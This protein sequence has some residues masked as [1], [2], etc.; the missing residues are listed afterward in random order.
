MEESDAEARRWLHNSTRSVGWPAPAA[1]LSC[2][3][4]SHAPFTYPHAPAF[5]IVAPIQ[6]VVYLA[7]ERTTAQQQQSV[8]ARLRPRQSPVNCEPMVE[9]RPIAGLSLCK[10]A[11]ALGLRSDL[12]RTPCNR[13]ASNG[14][15]WPAQLLMTAISPLPDSRM[16]SVQPPRL[17]VIDNEVA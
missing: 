15:D 7:C 6:S 8:R 14:S 9:W 2:P 16:T 4:H 17:T 13:Q 11:L 5:I 1:R 10:S 3:A 12:F